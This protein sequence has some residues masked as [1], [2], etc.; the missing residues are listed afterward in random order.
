MFENMKNTRKD[1]TVGKKCKYKI[2][3]Q[4]F[5][6]LKKYVFIYFQSCLGEM[7]YDR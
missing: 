5:N 6:Y 3:V 7:L 4:M 2:C 1:K